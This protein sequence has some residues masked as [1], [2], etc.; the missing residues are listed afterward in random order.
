ML[1]LKI[2]EK[3]YQICQNFKCIQSV[4]EA[5]L[6]VLPDQKKSIEKAFNEE[7]QIVSYPENH[8]TKNISIEE[9]KNNTIP[10][11]EVRN[12]DPKTYF[13]AKKVMQFKA[14]A[15]SKIKNERKFWKCFYPIMNQFMKIKLKI[16]VS[17]GPIYC[18]NKYSGSKHRDCLENL[19][20]EIDELKKDLKRVLSKYNEVMRENKN[21][22]VEEYLQWLYQK[23]T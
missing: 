21:N 2:T 7:L 15:C 19:N 10:D 17:K 12:V 3:G 16:Y 5:E 14:K 18:K 9:E 11:I 1:T 4:G 8:F 6:L 22:S 13:K 23:K 20:W